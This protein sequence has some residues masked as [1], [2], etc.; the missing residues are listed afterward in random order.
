MKNQVLPL[1]K[2]VAVVVAG[3]LV[4]NYVQTTFLS[5]STIAPATKA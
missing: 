1:L 2:S 3:V 4:A 5:K